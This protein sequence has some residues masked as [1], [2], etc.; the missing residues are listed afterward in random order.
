MNNLKTTKRALITSA[1]SLFIC[2]TMLL[3]T[4]FAWFTDSVTSNGNIIQ[5]GT[6]DVEM[7]WAEGDEDPTADATV[8]TDASTGAIFKGDQLWEP[9]YTDAKHF[10]ILNNGTLALNYQLRI[11]ANGIVSKLADVIDVYYFENATQVTR[12]TA[13]TGTKLGTLTDILGTGKNIANTVNGQLLATEEKAI[14][15]VFKMQESAGN[16]YQNLTVA[17]DF[18]IELIATQASYEEDSFGKDYDD[19]ALSP[20]VPP[21]LVRPL[22]DLGIDTTGSKLGMDLGTLTL[23]TGY[24]FEPAVSL[25][26]AQK[27]EYRY[28]HAD[29]VVYADATVPAN[30]M[31][32]AGYYDA[33]CSLNNDK[34]VAL[35]ADV[36]IPAG[37]QVRLVAN[38]ANGFYVNWEELCEYGNDGIGFRCGAA[39]LTGANA[40]TTL[41]V[42]LRLYEVKDKADSDTNSNNE[43]TGNYLT[44]GSFQYTFPAKDDA[45]DIVIVKDV[46]ELK[47]AVDNAVAGTTTFINFANDIVGDVTVTQLANANV[48]INGCGNKFNGVMTVFGNG[49]QGGSESLTIKNINFVA[50]NGAASCIVSPDRT[51]Q[52]PATYSYSHNVSVENCTFTDPDGIVNCAAIRQ[53]D[54]GDKNWTIANCTVDSTMHSILQV[55]NVEGKLTITGCNVYSKNGANLNSCTNVEMTG[56]TF[57][58]KGYAV[59]FGVGSGGNLGT[60]KSYVLTDNKLESTGEEEDAVIIFRASAVDAVLTLNNTELIGTPKYSG[61]TTATTIIV[62]D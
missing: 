23:D 7:Y 53:E 45:T 51:A 25:A 32:L 57:V 2:F 13:E 58:V 60:P 5:S 49:K 48:V 19:G 16:E 52:T 37:E 24:Q 20:L 30:S 3:G 6:L 28:W 27:S 55:N 41:T 47:A 8:W 11:V 54:G 34:W 40:G 1:V 12:D 4:T 17:T 15:L 38:M 10:K 14:T 44:L 26:E 43:E 46:A 50:A 36:D 21:A 29:F 39:D 62:N 33:W 42:E 56:C 31:A 61:N 18:S 9:G 59:R 35:T 22:A